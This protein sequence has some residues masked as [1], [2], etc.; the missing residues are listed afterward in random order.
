MKAQL[1]GEKM[2]RMKEFFTPHM[3]YQNNGQ[4]ERKI[5]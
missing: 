2:K 5:K 1:N 4:Y 3:T